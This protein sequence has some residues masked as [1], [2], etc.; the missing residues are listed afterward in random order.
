MTNTDVLERS[1]HEDPRP[2]AATD[3]EKRFAALEAR[4]AELERRLA[5][6]TSLQMDENGNVIVSGMTERSG[7][8][9]KVERRIA[10]LDWCEETLNGLGAHYWIEGAKGP[11]CANCGLI[12]ETR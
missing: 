8:V 7:R 6:L 5:F 12:R 11:A 4:C 9:A 3:T 1:E 10:S 2:R